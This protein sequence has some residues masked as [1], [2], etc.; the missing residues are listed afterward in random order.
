MCANLCYINN[1][2]FYFIKN[3]YITKNYYLYLILLSKYSCKSHIIVSANSN[4]L[5]FMI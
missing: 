3:Y 1:I 4:N 5:L 2:N